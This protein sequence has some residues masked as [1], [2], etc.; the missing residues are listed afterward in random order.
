M[1]SII[2]PC[3]NEE[4]NVRR[5]DAELLP[6]LDGLD[7]EHEVVA[8]DDGST[9]GT[10]EALK[11]L[12]VE[13]VSLTPRQ[14]LG[15]ALRAGIEKAK[16][17]WIVVLDADLTFS[18]SQIKSLI[19]C[20]K[21]TGADMVSGSPFLKAEG[22]AAVPWRRRLPSLL[23]NAFYR[24]LLAHRLTS[25]TPLF[26]LY[27]AAVLKSFPLKSA[28]FEINAE[29]AAR[30]ARARRPCAEVPA[31][32]RERSAGRSKLSALPE[33]WRHAR[34]VLRLLSESPGEVVR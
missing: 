6:T 18:P 7:V 29:I 27:R 9:D 13:L 25:Y 14:G 1:L 21:A 33:L 23:L 19:L 12:P 16:G 10:A 26:R 4:E 15:S 31:V 17:D 5:F 8:V 3:H 28:G 2:I 34:L 30:F 24:G 22:L 32:L 11:K 20:Q